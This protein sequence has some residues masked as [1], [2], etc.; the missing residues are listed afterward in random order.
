MFPFTLVLFYLFIYSYMRL[1]YH[2]FIYLFIYA[3]VV[4]FIYLFIYLVYV[5]VQEGYGVDADHVLCGM[6]LSRVYFD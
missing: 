1:W 2:L 3:L 6:W 4:S 5:G